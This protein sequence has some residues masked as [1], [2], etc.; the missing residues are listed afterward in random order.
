MQKAEMSKASSAEKHKE[1]A[2]EAKKALRLLDSERLSA[3]TTEVLLAAMACLLVIHGGFARKVAIAHA[4]VGIAAK[5]VEPLLEFPGH[6]DIAAWTTTLVR[7]VLWVVFLFLTQV[8]TTLTLAMDASLVGALLVTQHSAR[9]LAAI[10]KMAD[11]QAF[12]ASPKGLM[13]FGDAMK[14]CASA[15]LPIAARKRA[16]CCVTRRAP[17]SEASIASVRVVATCV[18]KRKTTQRTRRTKVVVHAAMSSCPGNSSKGSTCF[19]A[20]PTKA[21]GMATFRAKPP[22]ITKRQAMAARSTS[23]VAAESLSESNNRRAFLATS[24]SSLCFSADEAFDISAFCFSARF[25]ACLFCSSFVSLG[26]SAGAS[27]NIF[28]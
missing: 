10:G 13:A 11:A 21:W 2:E 8:A 22:W 28:S 23:V 1:D 9:F 26:S 7:L 12:I 14:A 5:Q 6:E 19:A 3:A 25:L 24:A 16:L 18:R 4:L 20:M 15:I 27:A 17:T